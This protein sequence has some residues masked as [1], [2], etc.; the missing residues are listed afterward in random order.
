MIL[1]E[2]AEFDREQVELLTKNLGEGT[3][4][5]TRLKKHYRRGHTACVGRVQL[6]LGEIGFTIN[7]RRRSLFA[8][9]LPAWKT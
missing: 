6:Y 2:D 9:R 8:R 4:I 1:N 7:S 5:T 3:V